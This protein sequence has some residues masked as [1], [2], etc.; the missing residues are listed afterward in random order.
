MEVELRRS[1][2]E[3]DALSFFAVMLSDHSPGL[4]NGSRSTPI[5]A[6]LFPLRSAIVA[7]LSPSVPQTGRSPHDVNEINPEEK[8]FAYRNS[9]V[10]TAARNCSSD[11]MYAA[12]A[13]R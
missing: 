1:C 11:V 9:R 2:A 4:A 12:S 10:P 3:V 13:W 7:E 6:E 8:P 5:V